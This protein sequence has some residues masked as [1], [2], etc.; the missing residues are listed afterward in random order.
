MTAILL[1]N[2]YTSGFACD[3]HNAVVTV[4]NDVHISTYTTPTYGTSIISLQGR[5]F[6]AG[7]DYHYHSPNFGSIDEDTFEDCNGVTRVITSAIWTHGNPFFNNTMWLVIDTASGI[8]PDNDDVFRMEFGSG[9]FS[10]LGNDGTAVLNTSGRYWFWFQGT[11]PL[12]PTSDLN[13]LIG[14]A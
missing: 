9:T 2:T 5:G 1:A 3:D 10:R 4:V 14:P 8:T 6:D 7:L 13:L 12:T 11:D